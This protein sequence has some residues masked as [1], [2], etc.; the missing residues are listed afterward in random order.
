M[1][2]SRLQISVSR[3]RRAKSQPALDLG[4]AKFPGSYPWRGHSFHAVLSLPAYLAG[5]SS[6]FTEEPSRQGK[7]RGSRIHH[8][9]RHAARS[10]RAT[11]LTPNPEP[12]ACSEI[13]RQGRI[14]HDLVVILVQR[15][16]YIY[17]GS[18][19][20]VER[21]PDANIDTGVSRGMIDIQSN[22]IGVWP[23]ANESGSQVSS[24]PFGDVVQ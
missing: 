20:G 23:A 18:N 7:L 9:D 1:A 5:I 15:V 3:K 6:R 8:R 11:L 12:Q 17:V 14:T 22:E 24:P 13:R 10:V 19:S 21:K 2:A 4:D 16:L